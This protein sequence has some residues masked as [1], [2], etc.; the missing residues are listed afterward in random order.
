MMPGKLNHK[1]AICGTLYH[2]CIG[3]MDVKTYTPWRNIVDSIE[4]YKIFI[5]IRDYS[6]ETIDKKTAYE[7]LSKCDLTGLAD[8]VE[9]INTEI[10]DILSYNEIKEKNK[11]TIR[12]KN[13]E[14][15]CE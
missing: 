15:V 7:Q 13:D 11:V 4:H 2:S 5:I 10:K 12:A 1:C 9:E 14:I 3:C 6:N 8:F